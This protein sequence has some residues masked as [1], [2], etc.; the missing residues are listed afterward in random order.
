[1]LPLHRSIHFSPAGGYLATG[2]DDNMI[3]I[4]DLVMKKVKDQF[5]GHTGDVYT[6]DFLRHGS[7]LASE[8]HDRTVRLWDIETRQCLSILSIENRVM[9]VAFS[10]NGKALAAGALDRIICI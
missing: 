4:W 3:P 1:M 9:T 5:E 7:K 6:L 10:T 8:S 2:A